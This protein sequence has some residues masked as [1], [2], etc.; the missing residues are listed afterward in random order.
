LRKA[1]QIAGEPSTRT[2]YGDGGYY[3][4]AEI[5]E[6][7]EMLGI[8]GHLDL[9]PPGQLEDWDRGPFDPTE[10]DGMIYGRGAQDDKGPLVASMFA[11]KA[12]IEVGVKFNKRVRLILGMDEESLWRCMTHYK[13]LE[14]APTMGFSPDGFF[15]L[16]FAEKGLLQLKLEGS[17]DSGLKLSG[18]SAFNAVPDMIFYD[19]E[20]QDDQPDKFDQLFRL[21]IIA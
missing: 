19:G 5:G 10:E 1:L 3:G 17:N 18:G 2:H 15:P 9:V 6:G 8:L 11:V 21:A 20:R 16:I 12:L 4:Y 13:E 14:E 7:K